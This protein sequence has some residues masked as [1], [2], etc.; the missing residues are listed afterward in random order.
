M[1]ESPTAVQLGAAAET[2]KTEAAST[3]SVIS[4][5]HILMQQ[6]PPAAQ[7]QSSGFTPLQGESSGSFMCVSRM[8]TQQVAA[9]QIQQQRTER[10]DNGERAA[11]IDASNGR[12]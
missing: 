6:Q 1:P 11:D 3:P 4:T 5:M 7:T 2:R 12:V 9:K 8:R 10:S